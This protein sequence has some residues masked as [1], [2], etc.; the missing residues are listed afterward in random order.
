MSGDLPQPLPHHP[1]TP[2]QLHSQQYN[3]EI[4]MICINKRLCDSEI[5]F[6]FNCNKKLQPF[7]NAH[8]NGFLDI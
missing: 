8:C 5:F 1:V 2:K 7:K 3:N 4:N 6:K